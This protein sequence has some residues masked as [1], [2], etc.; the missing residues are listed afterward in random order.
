[1]RRATHGRIFGATSSTLI[2][3]SASTAN[4]TNY[5]MIA[6]NSLGTATSS[7]VSLTTILPVASGP[8]FS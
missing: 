5:A 1:M 4:E 2:I 7:I 8:P 3:S 6:S